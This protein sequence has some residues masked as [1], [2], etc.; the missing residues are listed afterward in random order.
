MGFD[1]VGLEEKKTI[2]Y[3]KSGVTQC[4]FSLST[5]LG[6]PAGKRHDGRKSDPHKCYRCPAAGDSPQR[7]R[8]FPGMVLPLFR[9]LQAGSVQVR[10]RIPVA[11]KVI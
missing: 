6:F 5:W 3:T 2:L 8:P 11:L 7:R 1:S 9:Q 4:P 10:E